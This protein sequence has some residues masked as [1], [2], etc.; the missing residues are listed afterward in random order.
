MQRQHLARVLVR[1]GVG[2]YRPADRHAFAKGQRLDRRVDDGCLIDVSDD[3]FQGLR[4]RGAAPI[5]NGDEQVVAPDIRIGG[6]AA[7]R[8]RERVEA[9]PGGFV[10]Q[11]HRPGQRIAWVG[12]AEGGFGQHDGERL[13]LARRDRQQRHVGLRSQVALG[14]GHGLD[15]STV[16]RRTVGE[17]HLL[18]RDAAP[19]SF[20]L[21]PIRTVLDTEIQSVG[22]ILKRDV[23]GQEVEK[24]DPL[25]F[26]DDAIL[27][28]SSP[29]A[30]RA[31]MVKKVVAGAAIE[32]VRTVP[33]RHGTAAVEGIVA[34]I[35]VKLVVAAGPAAAVPVEDVIAVA[36]A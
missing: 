24:V 28:V 36:A 1:E 18:D 17:I 6:G 30:Y 27:A 34:G 19:V 12:V 32:E 15:G 11:V 20:E 8:A 23:A 13:A 26:A 14:G 33:R 4:G 9:K 16:P 31:G 29:V 10:R 35:A 21:Q 5:S 22:L 25:H 7:E 3:H 2:R